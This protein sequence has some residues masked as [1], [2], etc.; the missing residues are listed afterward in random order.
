MGLGV[1]SMIERL[2]V[3]ARRLAGM[4]AIC[5]IA[6][7]CA[8]SSDGV[9]DPLEGL[10]RQVFAF[11]DAVDTVLVRP[12]VF[13]YRETTPDFFK[14][15]LS[16]FLDNL[17][18]PLTV[19]HDLLQGKPERAQVAFGRLF[20]N[21]IVGLGGVFDVATPTGLVLHQ[22]DMGQT[23]AVHGVG[24]GPYLVLPLIG[25]SSVR[26]ATGSLIDLFLDPVSLASYAVTSGATLRAGRAAA[27]G[28]VNREELTEATDALRESLDYYAT[29]RSAYRQ[30]RGSDIRDGAP[31][32]YDGEADPFSSFDDREPQVLQ[33]AN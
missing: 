19:I 4:M 18:M 10:N 12:V 2:G 15:M 31:E 24:S 33:P 3:T 11:N 21:T 22:E 17:T 5:A 23:M 9:N 28:L 6:S 14:M 20:L 27:A 13:V 29:V 1:R 30:R 8:S 26:D 7:A 16:N 25:P 32:P